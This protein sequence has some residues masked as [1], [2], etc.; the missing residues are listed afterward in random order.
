MFK[1]EYNKQF[2]NV[3]PSPALNEETLALM[4]EAQEHPLPKEAKPQKMR[5]V[6]PVCVSSA[7][8]M[9]ALIIGISFWLS[10]PD[11]ID[12]FKGES[13]ILI[14][15]TDSAISGNIGATKD[16]DTLGSSLGNH[17]ADQENNAANDSS[18][19]SG[20]E[21]PPTGDPNAGTATPK[22]D[23]ENAAQPNENK[24]N[25]SE[26]ENSATETPD[27]E[28]EQENEMTEEPAPEDPPAE[29]DGAQ[30]TPP[31]EPIDPKAPVEINDKK[32]ETYLSLR[33]YLDAL[34]AKKTIGYKTAY[35]AEEA[36]IIVPSWLPNTARFRQ[37]YAYANGGY[38]YSYLFSY[39]GT[40]YFLNI[41]V[42]ATL[43]KT[44]RDLNLRVSGIA[45]EEHLTKKN[46]ANW[47]FYFGNYDKATIAVTAIDGKAI[48][49]EQAAPMLGNFSLARYTVQNTLVEA[50]YN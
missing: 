11:V 7:A 30:S 25:A 26:N 5:W 38:E 12:D 36:L 27:S 48:P 35:L 41:S 4:K 20:A 45:K 47:I 13:D 2:D 23:N 17:S 29:E 1:D 16:N 34:A 44:Q 18:T 9:L 43:P 19:N 49:T 6:L 24:E 39:E 3:A 32:T 40:D 15:T 33:A 10:K 8:A 50:T 22:D 28:T 42:S 31:A 46:P 21:E 37:I 14:G